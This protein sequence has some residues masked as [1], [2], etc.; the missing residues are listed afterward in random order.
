MKKKESLLK[1]IPVFHETEVCCMGKIAWMDKLCRDSELGVCVSV[2]ILLQ[3]HLF[4]YAKS[5]SIIYP[6]ILYF[7]QTDI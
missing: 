2:K 7:Q 6:V 3:V 1:Q 4:C 5:N